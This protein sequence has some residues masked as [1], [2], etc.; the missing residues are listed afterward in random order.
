MPKKRCQGGRCLHC[1][2][3]SS[4]F[5]K[6]EEK[7]ATKKKN[8]DLK[9]LKNKKKKN[10][11]HFV[12]SNFSKLSPKR[13]P[14]GRRLHPQRPQSVFEEDE[15]EEVAESSSSKCTTGYT[16]FVQLN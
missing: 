8:K 13:C 14:G 5:E 16:Y 15:A 11:P 6:N 7:E 9:N 1:Q 3:P 2:R 12:F 10:Q 4:V